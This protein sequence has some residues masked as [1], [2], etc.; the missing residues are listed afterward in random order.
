[1]TPTRPPLTEQQVGLVEYL[2][3]KGFGWAK[4]AK[5]IESQGWCSEKQH[6]TLCSMSNRVKAQ[7]AMADQPQTRNRSRWTQNDGHWDT[8]VA[9]NNY[10]GEEF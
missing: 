9:F 1:M 2:I 3:S 8:D 7:A 4:F 5:N 10:G 6:A